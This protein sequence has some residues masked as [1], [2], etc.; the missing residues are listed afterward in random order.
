M[1]GESGYSS[2]SDQITPEYYDSKSSNI[3][4]YYSW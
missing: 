3:S 2:D 1:E 4:E